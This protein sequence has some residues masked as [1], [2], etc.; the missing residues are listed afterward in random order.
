MPKLSLPVRAFVDDF[1]RRTHPDRDW[2][3]GSA[4]RELLL[5]PMSA[6]I[7]PLRHEIDV[8]KINQ[9]ITNYPYMRRED[10]DALVANMGKFRQTGAQSTGTVRMYFDRAA[11]YEFNY[12]EFVA[13]DSTV[14]VLQAPVR[15]TAT[16]LLAKRRSDNTFT[17][18]VGVR[19]IGL[20][21]RYALSAGSIVLVRNAPP[22]VLRVENVEDFTVTAP[23]ESNYDVVNALFKNLGL[24]NLVSRASIRAPLLDTFPGI[25]SLFVAGATHS[26]MLRDLITVEIDGN[27]V[28]LHVGGTVDVWVNTNSPVK[29][30]VIMSY[31]PSSKEL[32]IVSAKQAQQSALKYAFARL[33]LTSEGEYASAESNDVSLDE[34]SI[35]YLDQA[36]VPTE[37]AVISLRI[38]DRYHISSADVINGD[39]MIS[40]PVKNNDAGVGEILLVDPIGPNLANTNAA[41]GQTIRVGDDYYRILELAG[42]VIAAAPAFDTLAPVT[43]DDLSGS[44]IVAAGDRFIPSVAAQ[45]SVELLDRM[46]LTRGGAQGHYRVL[47][48]DATGLWVGRIR[49]QVELIYE[50]DDAVDYTYEV[51]SPTGG[52]PQ[53]P[54]DVDGT[55]WIYLGSDGAFDQNPALWLK[56]KSVTRTSTKLLITTIGGPGAGTYPATVVGGLRDALV[57][58]VSLF[59]ERPAGTDFSQGLS[60]GF[61]IGHTL[62]TNVLGV[63]AAAGS[64]QLDVLG[65]GNVVQCGDVLLFDSPPLLPEALRAATGGDGTKFSLLIREVVGPNRVIVSPPLSVELPASAR[66][67]VLRNQTALANA[68]ATTVIGNQVTIA[69][70]PLGLGDGMGMGVRFDATLLTASSILEADPEGDATILTFASGVAPQLA[71][72]RAGDTI[73]ITGVGGPLDGIKTVLGVDSAGLKVVIDG[74]FAANTWLPGV[75]TGIITGKRLDCVQAS[76]A[77]DTRTL[78]FKPERQSRALIMAAPGYV[79]PSP[80]D[81]GAAVRQT[82]AGTTYAGVLSSYDNTSNT[83]VIVP[84][85]PAVDVFGL[86][87]APGEEITVLSSAATAHPSTVGALTPIDYFTPAPSDIGLLV[88]Q[89]TYVGLLVSYLNSPTFEWKVKPLSEYDLFDGIDILTFVDRNSTGSPVPGA[90]QGALREPATAPEVNAGAV[91]LSLSAPA[92]FVAA[93]SLEIISRWGRAGGFFDGKRFRVYGDGVVNSAPF[94]GIVPATTQLLILGGINFDSYSLDAVAQYSLDLS[95]GAP[96]DDFLRIANSPGPQQLSVGAPVS[97][98]S[99]ALTVPGSRLGLWGHAGRV[100]LLTAAGTVHRVVLAGPS[101]VDGVNLLDP[102]PV[103]LFPTQAITVEIV[104]GFHLPFFLVGDGAFKPYRIFTP[105]DVGNVL[106]IGTA[107]VHNSLLGVEDR[108]FDAG[109]NFRAL[110]GYSDTNP[111]AQDLLLYVDSGPDASVTGKAIVGLV[112]DNTLLLG[113][114]FLHTATGVAYHIV[115]KNRAMTLE[116]WYEA[117]IIDNDQIQLLVDASFDFARFS[118]YQGWQITVRPSPGLVDYDLATPFYIP[119]LAIVAYDVGTRRLTLDVAPDHVAESTEVNIF[120]TAVAASPRGFQ[121]AAYRRRVRVTFQATERVVATAVSGSAIATF[122]YY[123]GGFFTLPVVKIQEVA[124]LDTESLQPL[125]KLPFTFQVDDAGLRYGHQETNRLIITEPGTDVVFKPIRITYVTDP[126]IETIDNYLN[127]DDNRVLGS[128]TMAKRMETISV[129]IAVEVRSEKSEGELRNAVATYINTLSST[130]RVSKD[131]LIK[132]LY[133]LRIVTFVNTDSMVLNGTYY[134]LTGEETVYTN[135]SDIFGADTAAYLANVVSVTKLTDA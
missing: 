31:L 130:E 24:K 57:G 53:I 75:V 41:V 89:G 13:V 22:S 4:V 107:G 37:G 62:Y 129:D 55:H 58:T 63:D 8:V 79:S 6:L 85:N 116:H 59:F 56:V 43:F 60:Q 91:T 118:S 30:E 131:G 21:N 92:G 64:S 1:F 28:D 47:A 71:T 104:E 99:F 5:G 9:S 125:R 11:D 45:A 78:K 51:K 52:V 48:V 17:Y 33:F 40:L 103:T 100:M 10:L 46:V 119:P 36:G 121:P 108:F 42:R 94:A 90:A 126:S 117:E 134:Q 83:W 98:G 49:S 14:F 23:D 93:A 86:Y 70:W 7:Q 73:T 82:I 133:E 122:N 109:V 2:S 127:A 25:L 102:L 77:G 65:L 12:L 80:S 72:V 29:R 81:I 19:S 38:D 135:V 18:D 34:S 35:I 61:N 128:F 76:T 101:G 123:S 113:E 84:N 50:S 88:R 74:S 115:R 32:V 114:D 105:P 20:G 16:E 120:D 87:T 110:L 97:A 132:H 54:A 39:T 66:F 3:R 106:M 112:D 27:D 68:T 95:S 124:L 69:A 96:S 26:K 67:S 44:V 111:V 15:I